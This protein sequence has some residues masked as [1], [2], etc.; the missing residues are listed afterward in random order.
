MDAEKKLLQ[1]PSPRELANL[2]TPGEGVSSD[3]GNLFQS[4]H[5]WLIDAVIVSKLP[6]VHY[7]QYCKHN[8]ET[9]VVNIAGKCQTYACY[10]FLTVVLAPVSLVACLTPIFYD[11]EHRCGK[12]H[13]YVATVRPC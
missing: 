4:Y 8:G 7:C 1:P 9:H 6:V 13:R 10:S 3:Q 5:I 2:R 11:K 12:C